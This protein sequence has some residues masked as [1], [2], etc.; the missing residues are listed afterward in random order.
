MRFRVFLLMGWMFV[1]TS[2]LS[3]AEPSW[4]ADQLLDRRLGLGK[5]WRLA[6]AGSG[7]EVRPASVLEMVSSPRP[8]YAQQPLGASE[9]LR[10]LPA[11][12]PA[13]PAPVPVPAPIPV[14]PPLRGP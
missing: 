3:V 1:V 4:Q 13:A 2:P 8:P 12:R 11:V 5:T 9:P 14:P 7:R 10:P 6:R